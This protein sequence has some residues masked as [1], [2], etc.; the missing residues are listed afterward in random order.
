MCLLVTP[1]DSGSFALALSGSRGRSLS[2]ASRSHGG[3]RV[4]LS[5]IYTNLGSVG[6]GHYIPSLSPSTTHEST[7]GQGSKA[8]DESTPFTDEFG[9]SYRST[10][11]RAK[12]VPFRRSLRV[13]STSVI[14]GIHPSFA[15]AS[16]VRSII[17]STEGC[18]SSHRYTFSST[19]PAFV[20]RFLLLF[21]ARCEYPLRRRLSVDLRAVALFFRRL[22]AP[23]S[24]CSVCLSREQREGLRGGSRFHALLVR[25]SARAVRTMRGDGGP[26]VVHQIRIHGTGLDTGYGCSYILLFRCV[27]LLRLCLARGLHL[28]HF[29]H[30][31]PL[32]SGMD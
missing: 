27:R 18:D 14:C 32:L 9:S 22:C 29:G 12:M 10:L 8:A 3:G 6:P 13:L 5:G 4:P 2:R 21:L 30:V 26:P 1:A 16:A 15:G 7:L 20:Q 19:T 11:G 25:S 24:W 31:I 28:G 17:S 23:P